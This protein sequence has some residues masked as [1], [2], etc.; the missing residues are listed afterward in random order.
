MGDV[1]LITGKRGVGRSGMP[2]KLWSIMACNTPVI[3]SF[4]LDSELCKIIEQTNCGICVE[5][6]NSDKIVSAIHNM[7]AYNTNHNSREQVRHIA[8]KEKCTL[9]YLQLFTAAIDDK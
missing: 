8:S 2:S 7:K 6:E 3:A 5:P 4:D 1:A 9:D